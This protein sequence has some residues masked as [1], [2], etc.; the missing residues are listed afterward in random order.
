MKLRPEVREAL[1]AA[2]EDV[3]SIFATGSELSYAHLD[4]CFLALML[5]GA[6]LG[7]AYMNPT[8]E[9]TDMM[10]ADALRGE[11]E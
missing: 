6:K 8:A 10:A 7:M 4:N 5:I 3:E 1:D 11:H 9:I 2:E